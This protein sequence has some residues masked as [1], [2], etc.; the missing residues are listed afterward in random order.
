MTTPMSRLT[1][2]AAGVA[3]VLAVSQASGQ[4]AAPSAQGANELGEIVVTARQRE[5]KLTDVPVTI[6]AFTAADITQA[7]IE[8][9]QDFIALTP[10]LSVVQTA[11]IGDIQV[12][13]RGINTGRDA[14]TNFAFVVDGVLQTNPAA[15]NQEL[16]SVTQIEVLKGPQ[17]AVYGRNAVAGAMI[18]TT[19]K[20][21][22]QLEADVALG[23]GSAA[24]K[25][26]NL[27]ISG[28]LGEGVKASVSAYL[29]KTDGQW[30]NTFLKCGDCVDY[31]DEKGGQVRALLDVGGGTLDFKGKYSKVSSGAINFNGS[32]ALQELANALSFPLLSQDPNTQHFHYINDVKP[33]NN[34]RNLD[35]SLKGEWKLGANTLT[36]Y[37]AHNDQTNEFLTD[38]ASAFHQYFLTAACASSYT[39]RKA[40]TPFDPT[41][42]W[43]YGASLLASGAAQPVLPPYDATTCGGYQYQQR[44][45]KDTSVEV[46]LTSPGD[47]PLRWLAGVYYADVN[48]HVIVSTGEDTQNG[49]LSQ[50]FVPTSG[51]NPTDLLYDDTFQSKVIAGFGQI[52][53][54]VAPAVE[55]ALALRYDREK[56]SVDNNVPRCSTANPTVCRAQTPNYL[57]FITFG[58][59]PY[60]N[61]AYT[62]DPTLAT[63][64]I[65]SRDKTFSQLQPKLSVNW[66]F[67]DGW[68]LFGS[69]G[70]GFRSGGF[71]SS[72]SAA[73][74]Q[75][76]YGGLCLGPSQFT[77][78]GLYPAPC[79]ASSVHSVTG[80]NDDYKRELSKAAELGFK[81]LLF[82]RSVSLNGAIYQTKVEDM[83]F[84][85][86]FAGP[87]GILRVV[88]N[89]DQATIKGVE[90]DS[91]WKV[92]RYLTLFAG[93]AYT[94]SKIDQYSGR[95]Y[96][97][98]N[99]VPYAPLYT[100][101]AGAEL[102]VPVTGTSLQFVTR[103]DLTAVGET[104][105]SPVQKNVVPNL[106]G[107]Y[108]GFGQGDFSHQKRDPYHLFN[109]RLA[110]QSDVWSVTAWGHNLADKHYLAEVIPA[111]EFGGSFVHEAPG[112]SYGLDLAYHFGKGR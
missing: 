101:N 39:A 7:G 83:Q 97:A 103:V 33:T 110:L 73:T 30:S 65:P 20:P 96:T 6:Q 112:R 37:V 1:L 69:Y 66:K 71:N 59:V 35:F 87:F 50:G 89:L 23:G 2:L 82:D 56:R 81:A 11:E 55:V 12:S 48:R 77:N 47:Q 58:T 10:G 34:Q 61:P 13:I 105:F 42:P 64:G 90:L 68:S 99:K 4:T 43:G 57:N 63:N 44:D 88:S 21:T 104:W 102:S 86:F 62:A 108:G 52:A 67:A 24:L 84:F 107:L 18:M 29:R 22:D 72:G 31:L 3:A 25:K 98:G 19:R 109:A 74:V 49:Y 54:D 8:R 80:V 106:F 14:E 79:T 111:P 70:Y 5:E 17:G 93:Y 28:P 76:Y 40:D 46:R 94:D 51:P 53:Y 36:S 27:W 16:S 15:L 9:P 41:W 32:L 95:P 75:Q 26:G 91:K 78:G 92:N 85:N 60:I 45:Q 100:G 38:G